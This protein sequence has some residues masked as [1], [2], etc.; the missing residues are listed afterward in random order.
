MSLN[1][2]LAA[3]AD[4]ALLAEAE[5]EVTELSDHARPMVIGVINEA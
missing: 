4:E 5:T 2:K 3:S 1:D